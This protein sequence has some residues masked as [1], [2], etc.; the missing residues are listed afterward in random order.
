[1]KKKKA[2]GKTTVKKTE[3]KRVKSVTAKKQL[4]PAKVR[5]EIAG[6]VK[7]G[8][9]GITKAVVLA[10]PEMEKRRSP[11]ENIPAFGRGFSRHGG[12]SIRW[13]LGG[14]RT[15]PHAAVHRLD[16]P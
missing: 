6:I 8:A 5:E 4:D 10:Q 11:L 13:R 15:S 3:K 12:L 1:M 14:A 2:K 7:A 9:K 16:E